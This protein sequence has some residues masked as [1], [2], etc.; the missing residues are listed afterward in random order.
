MT[1]YRSFYEAIKV[2]PSDSQLELFTAIYELGLNEKTTILSPISS[3]IFELI[4]PKL[5]SNNLRARAG[6]E[7]GL[8]GKTHGHSGG[9][10]KTK[11]TLSKPPIEPSKNPL[12]ESFKKTAEK[13]RKKVKVKVDETE[14]YIRFEKYV[15]FVNKTFARDFKVTDLTFSSFKAR[16]KLYSAADL[17]N[18][19]RAIAQDNYHKVETNYLHA[20]VEFCL[21]T[22]KIEKYKDLTPK[23]VADS[24]KEAKETKQVVVHRSIVTQ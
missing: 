22:A 20:T 13:A 15:A 23:R 2:L 18:T 5:L 1:I 21:R 10:P 8:K 7:N 11:I 14:I 24:N 19:V 9:R 12:D 4:K 17:V 6:I 3:A 16:M